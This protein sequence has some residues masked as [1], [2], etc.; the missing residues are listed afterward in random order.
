M[1][2][3]IDKDGRYRIP[4]KLFVALRKMDHIEVEDFLTE[5]FQDGYDACIRDQVRAEARGDKPGE[6]QS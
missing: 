4:R 2:R 1:S 6:I 3:K 5:V